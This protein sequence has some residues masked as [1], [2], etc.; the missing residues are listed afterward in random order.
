MSA[1]EDVLFELLHMEI[2]KTF[3]DSKDKDDAASKLEYIGFTTGYRFVERAT[4]ETNRFKD[5]LDIMKYICKVFWVSV[6]KKE[7]DNLRTNHQGVY[8][9]NDNNFRFLTRISSGKQYL[10]YAP[11]FVTFTCGL[12]RGSLANLGINCVVTAEV[13]HL[14]ACKFQVQVQRG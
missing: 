14:P 12:I 1:A 13:S 10:Q 9:L 5:E 8:V 11:R 7:I 6:F 4:R 2:V 3:T